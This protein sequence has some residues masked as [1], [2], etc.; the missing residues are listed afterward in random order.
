MDPMQISMQDIHDALHATDQNSAAG[1]DGVHLIILQDCSES[2]AYTLVKIFSLSMVEACLPLERKTYTVTPIFKKGSCYS[3][4][5]YR[6]ISLTSVSCK[7][8]EHN[9]FK[10]LTG[11]CQTPQL[12]N[13]SIPTQLIRISFQFQSINLASKV[14]APPWIN[15]SLCKMKSQS[16]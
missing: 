14:G 2:L 7:C 9:M 3:P 13:T 6:P 1:P 11:D 15:C 8:L 12:S 10:T 16:G 4:L 5:K